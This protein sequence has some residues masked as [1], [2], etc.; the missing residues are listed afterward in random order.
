MECMENMDTKGN[1]VTFGDILALNVHK[2]ANRKS[3][4][5]DEMDLKSQAFMR[6]ASKF[7]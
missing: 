2:N 3:S 6:V 5:S 7:V 1:K 4:L